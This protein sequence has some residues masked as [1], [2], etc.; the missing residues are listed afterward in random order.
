[1]VKENDDFCRTND[2][3][4]EDDGRR[5]TRRRVI[6]TT[7]AAAAAGIFGAAALEQAG[8]APLNSAQYA[9]VLRQG[10]PPADAAPPEKQ[11]L[12]FPDNVN[13]AK[14]IDFYQAVYERPSDEHGNLNL[15]QSNARPGLGDKIRLIPGHCDPTVNL[16]DWYVGIRGMAGPA[17]VVES[18]W[19][20]A[21]RGALF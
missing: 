8:A 2:E 21:A 15:V 10:T 14:V 16:H 18:V 20:V 7:A 19:P 4:V 12:V 13:T 6:S 17:P 11:V 1:M 9:R 3:S 5:F